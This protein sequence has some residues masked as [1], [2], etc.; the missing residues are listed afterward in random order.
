MITVE[1]PPSSILAWT[2]AALDGSRLGHLFLCFPFAHPQV[3]PS[4]RP[5][6]SSDSHLTY[7]VITVLPWLYPYPIIPVTVPPSSMLPQVLSQFK[8]RARLSNSKFLMAAATALRLVSVVVSSI[9]PHSVLP[10]P[11]IVHLPSSRMGPLL[12]SRQVPIYPSRAA[13]HL[14]PPSLRLWCPLP[15]S[16]SLRFHDCASTRRRAE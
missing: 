1:W 11:S 13:V 6:S 16:C 14:C 15:S 4:C 3:V 9:S 12:P 2:V 10:R 7:P 8:E 5:L